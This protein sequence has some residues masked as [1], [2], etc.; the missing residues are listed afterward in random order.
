ML[1][2]KK[3]GDLLIEA[4]LITEEQLHAV[5]EEQRMSKGRLGD[6]L[7]SKSYV[8][9]QQ[10][11]ETLVRQLGI[12][13]VPVHQLQIDPQ[14]IALIPQK[15]AERQ[16]VLPLSKEGNKLVVAMNNPLDYFAIDELRM[17]TGMQIMP[18]ITSKEELERAISRFYGFQ[19][20]VEQIAKR[21]EQH[22]LD[23]PAML[24]DDI[25]SPVIKTVNQ[26]IEQA[27][28]AGASDI[29]FDPQEDGLRIRYRV[30]GL[31]RS[32]KKLPL[33]MQRVIAARVKIMAQLDIAERRLPHDGRMELSVDNRKIDIRISTMPTMYG[34]KVVMRILDSQKRNHQLSE[35]GFTEHNLRQFENGINSPYGMVLIAGPTGSGKT[36]T[37]YSALQQ[38]NSEEANIVTIEDPVEYQLLG[39]NQVQ[40]NSGPG[41]TFSIGLRALL[42]QDPDIAMVGE[43]RDLE[44]A[45]IS[46]R[47]AMTGHLVLST[48]HANNA[49]N[50][51]T[52][53][54]EMGVEPF[55]LSSSLNCVVAQRLVRCV[56]VNCARQVE[57]T[58]GERR[59]FEARG[60]RVDKLRQGA[61][62]MQCSQTGYRGRVAIHEVLLLDDQL[63][64]MILRSKGDSEYRAY[65]E[66]HGLI[67]LLKDGLLKAASGLTTLRE[68]LRVTSMDSSQAIGF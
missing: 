16:K 19:E 64:S 68:V 32:E 57:P 1:T 55:L 62:C 6:L 18:A 58:P 50:A 25:Y 46:V 20:S 38:V 33:H 51:V 60:I 17:T 39:I 30:D 14:V 63:R 48:L 5:L 12:P 34:E 10:V 13:Y 45:E 65:A 36:T 56:C 27:I 11:I 66:R 22:E 3:L 15:L 7:I 31:L 26:I 37:L 21:L 8:S 61:G 4:G 41:L 52:R 23:D 44:T 43:I 42:R 29:H 67:P 49:V 54:M 24:Q 2:R 35:L 28:Q 59:L 53:L 40:V 9:E 47:A